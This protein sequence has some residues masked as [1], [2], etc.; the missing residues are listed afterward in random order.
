MDREQLYLGDR[1]WSIFKN[2][3][4]RWSFGLEKTQNFIEK[5]NSWK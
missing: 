1:K 4:F 5:K 3:F 2:F